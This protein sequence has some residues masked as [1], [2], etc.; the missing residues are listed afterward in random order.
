MLPQRHTVTPH[1]NPASQR[2]I[3]RLLINQ[4]LLLHTCTPSHLGLHRILCSVA[5]R[6][7]FP[8]SIHTGPNVSVALAQSEF[9]VLLACYANVRLPLAQTGG[10]LQLL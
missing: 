10:V 3:A 9:H 2:Q 8:L 1:V 5:G 4:H 7:G 6:S